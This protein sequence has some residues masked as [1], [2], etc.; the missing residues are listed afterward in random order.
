[1]ATEEENEAKKAYVNALFARGQA[2]MEDENFDPDK[3]PPGVTH[4]V[5][6]DEDGQLTVRRL[7]FNGVA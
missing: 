3:L 6:R 1:M 2:V 5:S 4:A 7:R